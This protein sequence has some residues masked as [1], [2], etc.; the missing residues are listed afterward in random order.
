M[1][2]ATKPML[3]AWFDAYQNAVQEQRIKQGNTYNMDESGF[4]IG[5][6]EWTPIVFDLIVRVKHQ[7]YQVIKNGFQWLSALARRKYPSTAWNM[8]REKRP[9]VIRYRAMSSMNGSFQ[10]IQ[11]VGQGIFMGETG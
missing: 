7:A 6:M 4:S 10:R 1:D 3:D 11:R 2:S 8:Q 5:S 9:S